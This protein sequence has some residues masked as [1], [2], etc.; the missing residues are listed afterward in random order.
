MSEPRGMGGTVTVHIGHQENIYL[1]LIRCDSSVPL[2]TGHSHI[3]C[4]IQT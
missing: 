4:G 1:A 2:N 3:G